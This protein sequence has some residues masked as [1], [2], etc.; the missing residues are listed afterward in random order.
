MEFMGATKRQNVD[1]TDEAMK[2]VVDLKFTHRLKSYR[3]AASR[4]IVYVLNLP[5]VDR[6]LIFDDTD[7]ARMKSLVEGGIPGGLRNTPAPRRT[8]KKGNG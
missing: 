8:K 3:I 1:L 4:A 6:N 5:E 2:A 7:G